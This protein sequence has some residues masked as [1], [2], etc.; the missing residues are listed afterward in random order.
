MGEGLFQPLHLL[1]I[2]VVALLVFGPKKIPEL[3]KGLGEGIKNFKEGMKQG[4]DTT[5]AKDEAPAPPKNP[6]A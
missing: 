6:E 1:V 5:S 3:G 4:S 2:V